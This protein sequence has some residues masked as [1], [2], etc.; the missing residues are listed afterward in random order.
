RLLLLDLHP[1]PTRRSSDLHTVSEFLGQSRAIF[2]SL[3]HLGGREAGLC[4]LGPFGNGTSGTW[5]VFWKASIIQFPPTFCN[6]KVCMPSRSEEH[7]SELQSRVDLVC[8]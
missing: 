3:H 8:R 5:L 6:T 1:F 2:R 4:P 7:T